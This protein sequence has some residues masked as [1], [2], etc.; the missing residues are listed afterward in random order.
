MDRQL[1]DKVM[2]NWR[3]RVGGLAEATDL[4]KK[5]L[6]CSRSKAEKLAACRYPSLP[7]PTE[8]KALAKLLKTTRDV[9]FPLRESKAS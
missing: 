8:Q 1:N 2:A 3:E 4:I 9:L 5:A 6:E 7:T